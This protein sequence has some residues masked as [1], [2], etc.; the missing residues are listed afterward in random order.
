METK[1]PAMPVPESAVESCFFA[2]LES[3][4]FKDECRL[5]TSIRNACALRESGRIADYQ[6]CVTEDAQGS[7]LITYR[8]NRSKHII[9]VHII[10]AK[11]DPNTSLAVHLYIVQEIRPVESYAVVYPSLKRVVGFDKT[12]GKWSGVALIPIVTQPI[13]C[14]LNVLHGPP[15]TFT[16]PILP[17]EGLSLSLLCVCAD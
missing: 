2:F 1:Q 7:T 16:H 3:H 12:N 8:L 13:P 17:L 4:S 11:G 9:L 15:K 14:Q 6:C 10:K 5:A